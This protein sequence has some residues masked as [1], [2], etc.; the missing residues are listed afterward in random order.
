[1]ST[2]LFCKQPSEPQFLGEKNGYHLLACKACGSVTTEPEVTP[3]VQKVMYQEL[4]IAPAHLPNLKG[5]IQKRKRLI[6]KIM[7]GNLKGKTFLDVT[8]GNGYNV[9]AARDLGMAEPRGI[10]THDFLVH[11]ARTNYMDCAFENISAMEYAARGGRADMIF[12]IDGF[13]AQFDVDAYTAALAKILNPGGKMYIEDVDGNSM[14]LSRR[15][16]R[17]TFAEPPLNFNYISLK[18][19]KKL[20]SRH[21]LKVQRKLFAGMTPAMRL[22][23]VKNEG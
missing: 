9:R 4:Q 23:V 20:L 13:S 22:V 3:E 16:A 6:G 2:C 10:D 18:G 5:E 11:F 21:G 15:T 1:M 8:S 19:M 17:W 12:C 7:N 14:W